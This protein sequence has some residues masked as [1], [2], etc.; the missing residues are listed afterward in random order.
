MRVTCGPRDAD[1]TKGIGLMRNW[2]LGCF[3]ILVGGFILTACGDTPPAHGHA[4]SHPPPR[5]PRRPRPSP[6]ATPIPPLSITCGAD[7]VTAALVPTT[8]A[9]RA[10]TP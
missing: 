3:L 1:A 9:P 2:L 8:P 4:R 6:T 7:Q 10:G 5:R